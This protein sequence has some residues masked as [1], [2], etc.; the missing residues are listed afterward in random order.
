MLAIHHSTPVFLQ[1]FPIFTLKVRK[2]HET[3]KCNFKVLKYR[4]TRAGEIE[5]FY[6]SLFDI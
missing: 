2:M 6:I 5:M 3:T 4:R 1:Q